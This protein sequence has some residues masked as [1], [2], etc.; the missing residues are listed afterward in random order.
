MRFTSRM[1]LTTL[2]LLVSAAATPQAASGRKAFISAWEGSR[3]VVTRTL[4]SIVY[5][6]R[7]RVVP[8]LKQEG[9]VAGLTVA[10][11]SDTYYLFEA[12][13]DSEED[14]IERDPERLVSALKTQYRRSSHL[15][16]G[17]TQDVEPVMLVRYEPGVQ[18]VVTAVRIERDRVQLRFNKLNEDTLATTLTVKWPAP[19]TK[20]LTESYLIERALTRFI[21]KN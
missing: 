7:N 10:T 16:I 8:L 20:E 13:R 12:R 15:D 4:F 2:I 3:V 19:L 18:F 5:D 21:R 11:P 6:E 1:L 9:R 17:N 14:I